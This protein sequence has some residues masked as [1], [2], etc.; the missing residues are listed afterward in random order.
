M[1]VRIVNYLQ[2]IFHPQAWKTCIRSGKKQFIWNATNAQN[3]QKQDENA[4]WRRRFV[5]HC[6]RV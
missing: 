2:N 3:E 1:N 4:H 5:S 6:I